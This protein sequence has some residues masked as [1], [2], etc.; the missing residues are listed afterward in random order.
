MEPRWRH[1]WAEA[2]EC[3]FVGGTNTADLWIRNGVT[4]YVRIVVGATV[5]DW[6][7]TYWEGDG[8]GNNVNE[9]AMTDYYREHK[10]EIETYLRLFVPEITINNGELK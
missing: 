6:G 7:W 2:Y 5:Y 9:L 10:E 4:G 1:E 3:V 8:L